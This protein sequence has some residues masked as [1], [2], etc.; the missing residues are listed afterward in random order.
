MDRYQSTKVRRRLEFKR[1][2][3]ARCRSEEARKVL[4]N[5]LTQFY[6]VTQAAGVKANATR[7]QQAAEEMD[8]A[9]SLQARDRVE[10]K[11]SMR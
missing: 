7:K 1:M 4:E 9:Q 5:Y 3:L 6:E 11:P 10:G 2:A 8:Y